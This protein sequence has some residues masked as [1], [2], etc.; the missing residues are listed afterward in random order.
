MSAFAD[1]I[2]TAGVLGV[3]KVVW[4]ADLERWDEDPT[5]DGRWTCRATAP[6]VGN[7][8]V[9]SDGRTG[10][11]ALRRVVEFLKGAA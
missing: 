10:E 11:E 3:T 2:S 1:L 7:G 8:I 5:R 4:E 6:R 9:E